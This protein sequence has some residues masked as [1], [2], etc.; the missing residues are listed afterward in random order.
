MIK[1]IHF[2]H[3]DDL[4]GRVSAAVM[5]E[6]LKRDK[7]YNKYV[8]HEIDY[9]IDLDF[10]SI[11]AG[12]LLVFTDYSFSNPNNL[13]ALHSLLNKGTNNI[14]WIDH[15]KTSEDIIKDEFNGTVGG[16]EHTYYN[17]DK[18]CFEYYIDTS[19]C[20][21]K[22]CYLWGLAYVDKRERPEWRAAYATIPEVIKYVDSYDRWTLVEPHTKEFDYGM[23]E[24]DY[25]PKT[26]FRE[27]I[28]D[29]TLSIFDYCPSVHKANIKFIDKIIK[30]GTPI[31]EYQFKKYAREL[32]YGGFQ[33]TITDKRI[34][35][36]TLNGKSYPQIWNCF[37][38]NYH[39]GS[40]VFGELYNQYDIVCPFVFKKNKFKYSLF[41]H[42]VDTRMPISRLNCSDIASVL[43]N[44]KG[45][46][47]GGGHKYAAGFQHD[48]LLLFEG[49]NIIIYKN[50]FGKTKVKVK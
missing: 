29:K 31:M 4:D 20:A 5:Y 13:R 34:N 35:N 43:G 6:A 46:H 16:L 21:A 41:S 18:I 47:G 23:S 37:A 33:F 39:S 2:F 27:I 30:I 28:K 36:K 40:D 8:F 44:M 12:D 49:C 24:F 1:A 38:V 45:G 42:H 50:I 25:T 14:I 7:S 22:L 15:H 26:L 48:K 9:T 19:Y 3:H 17:N 11:P 32:K 10:G